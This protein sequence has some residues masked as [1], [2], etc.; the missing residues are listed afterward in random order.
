MAPEADLSSERKPPQVT[1]ATPDSLKGKEGKISSP[2]RGRG[3]MGQD[4]EPHWV[5]TNWTG[6]A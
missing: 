3:E 5:T 2:N 4:R 1:R 6:P